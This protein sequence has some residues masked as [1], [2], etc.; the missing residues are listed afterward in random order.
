MKPA[1]VLQSLA[2]LMFVA[3]ITYFFFIPPALLEKNSDKNLPGYWGEPNGEFDWCEANYRLGPYIA[4]PWNTATGLS[5]I[6]VAAVSL[7]YYYRLSKKHNLQLRPIFIFMFML[8][9]LAIAT[10]LFHATLQYEHQLLDEI[11]MYYIITYGFGMVCCH[12][13][14]DSWLYYSSIG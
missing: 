13:N 12:C 10:F 2:C 11:S 3:T 14:P 6:A 9:P 4:E 5:Y 8:F 7:P 1:F